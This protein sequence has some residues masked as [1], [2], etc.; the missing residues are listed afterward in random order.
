MQR[1]VSRS[2]TGRVLTP[3]KEGIKMEG[4]NANISGNRLFKE[5]RN[6]QSRKAGHD[7]SST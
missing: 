4:V 2:Q 5:S 6:N 3:L 1:G 7:G